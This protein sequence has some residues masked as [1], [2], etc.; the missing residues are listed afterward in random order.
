MRE[1]LAGGAGQ[2][3]ASVHCGP[4]GCDA[5]PSLPHSHSPGQVPACTKAV[6]LGLSPHPSWE[7]FWLVGLKGRCLNSSLEKPP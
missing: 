4:N 1:E 2:R 7:G 5:S 6:A 3:C